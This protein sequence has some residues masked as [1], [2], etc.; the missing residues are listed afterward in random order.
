MSE[1]LDKLD[2]SVSTGDPKCQVAFAETCRAAS[3]WSINDFAAC[4]VSS[5][6]HCEHVLSYVGRFYCHHPRREE[7]VMRTLQTAEKKRLQTA[8]EVQSSPRPAV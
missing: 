5:P 3:M 1:P 4:L 2:H 6:Q 7:I 8:L